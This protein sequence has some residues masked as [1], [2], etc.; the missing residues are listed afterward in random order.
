MSYKEFPLAL[1]I[2]I[3]WTLS[4]KSYFKFRCERAFARLLIYLISTQTYACIRL[5]FA[6]AG[7]FSLPYYRCVKSPHRIFTRYIFS[8]KFVL[9]TLRFSILMSPIQGPRLSCSSNGQES[10]CEYDSLT[11]STMSI[12]VIYIQLTGHM[13]LKSFS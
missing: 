10:A 6:L 11:C 1:F 12:H 13:Y 4:R 7:F 9:N 2:Y 5:L 3:W 8:S